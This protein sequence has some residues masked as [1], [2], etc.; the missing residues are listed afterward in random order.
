MSKLIRSARAKRRLAISLGDFNM[1]PS[2][3]AYQLI[4]T[5]G[6]AIDT[7]KVI[8]PFSSLGSTLDEPERAR[9]VP[10]PTAHVNLTENGATCD[11]VLNTWRWDEN[12]KKSL[13]RG[14]LVEVDPSTEDP[15]A[16][17]LDYIFLGGSV[18]GWRVTAT[19]VGMV[20]RHPNLKVSLSDHFSVEV[21]IERSKSDTKLQERLTL[22]DEEYLPLET[23]D[24]IL[25]LID[26]YIE[27]E[28]QQ[29]RYRLGHLGFGFGM[30]I[31][32]L[33]SVWW[34][35]R[36]FV[37]FILMLVSSLALTAGVIDGLI[38]GLFMSSELRSLKEFRWEM[39]NVKLLS[40]IEFDDLKHK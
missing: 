30:F 24:A 19:S 10:M 1:I 33:I 9:G 36:N 11:S 5:H 14:E 2:S 27:R 15:N 3:L 13:K 7:W 26:H 16:K 6:P 20:E 39:E 28:R 32:C 8:H 25:R 37:S 22:D 23:Y 34:S 17:R 29:R 21:T 40:T 18:E 35:P 12:L 31:A 38:G 4:S